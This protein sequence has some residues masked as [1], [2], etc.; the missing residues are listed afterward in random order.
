[1]QSQPENSILLPK[2][3]NETYRISKVL[4]PERWELYGLYGEERD[5]YKRRVIEKFF[6]GWLY[7]DYV[8]FFESCQIIKQHES[9]D[10]TYGFELAIG[11]VL[12]NLAETNTKLF[13]EVLE[14]ILK[15]GNQL[16]HVYPRAIQHLISNTP[17]LRDVYNLLKKY[18]YNSKSRW[19]FAFLTQLNSEQVNAFYLNEL[20]E[21]Y[22]SADLREVFIYFDSL[23]NYAAI[24]S[25][26]LP[27]VV[28]ILF[29]RARD[30]EDSVRFDLLFNPYGE[31]VTGLKIIFEGEIDLLKDVYLYEISI[32]RHADYRG[33]ALKTILE[34]DPDFIVEY[35]EHITANEER[36]SARSGGHRYSALWEL[37]NY[38]SIISTA[39]EYILQKE[40]SG[41][42]FTESYANVFFRYE[43]KT[44]PSEKDLLMQQRMEDFVSN[45]IRSYYKDSGQMM[46]IF[47][48]VKHSFHNKRAY[49]LEIF[50]HL[51]KDFE[52]FRRLN[53][54][55]HSWSTMG[56]RIPVFE[57]KIEFLKSILPLFTSIEFLKHKIC[58][59]NEILYWKGEIQDANKEEFVS[60]F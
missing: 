12:N 43:A 41:I 27:R 18:D 9:K 32:D 58:V 59:E 31:T 8:R 7:G 2:F 35:L 19:L 1:M 33:E 51:N 38:E 30:S 11:R 54:E 28:K 24:D 15:S 22:R 36:L 39:L 3:T 29:E 26:V 44:S 55:P 56:S 60:E 49:F 25:K 16:S 34:I 17:N 21:L 45:Y 46:F 57:R 10:N 20:Y 5:K 23:A 47:D 40:N 37:E 4:S 14:Y 53:I 50:L 52:D 6:T 48:I 42:S 13:N